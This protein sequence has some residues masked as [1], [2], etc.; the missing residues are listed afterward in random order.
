M[1]P[2]IKNSGLMSDR[3]AELNED[4]TQETVLCSFPLRKPLSLNDHE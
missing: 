2:K 4:L 1:G 3:Q